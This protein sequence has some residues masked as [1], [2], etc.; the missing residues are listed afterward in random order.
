MTY[1]VKYRKVEIP[2]LDAFLQDYCAVCEKHGIQL[3]MGDYGYDGGG[4][5]S[6]EKFSD[7]HIRLNMDEADLQIPFISRINAE[8]ERLNN[9]QYAAGRQA[10]AAA[11]KAA[12]EAAEQ[13][14]ITDGVVLGGKRYKLVQSD[15]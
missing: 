10:V 12:Q 6:I 5:V 1:E 14:A 2:E 13:R 11:A 4:Y 7:G 15:G 3:L 9:E 8:A